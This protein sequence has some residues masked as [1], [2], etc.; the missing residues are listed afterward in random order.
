MYVH[1]AFS[2]VPVLL[3]VKFLP[4]PLNHFTAGAAYTGLSVL[5]FPL[6]KYEIRT[7]Y[8]ENLKSRNLK[9]HNPVFPVN[10]F[11]SLQRLKKNE[12]GSFQ[13]NLL[14]VEVFKNG[15]VSKQ[16]TWGADL[17]NSN[18]K[19]ITTDLCYK[20]YVNRMIFAEEKWIQTKTKGWVETVPLAVHV[21][22]A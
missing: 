18:T 5:E 7:I 9:K 14:N 2:T 6:W 10:P 11:M 17:S 12:V 8:S 22:T 20:S 13:E 19:R 3:S 21:I 1:I 4:R 15:K 16:N